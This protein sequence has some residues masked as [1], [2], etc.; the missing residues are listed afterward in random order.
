MKPRTDKEQELTHEVVSKM[1]SYDADTGVIRHL[2]RCKGVKC[3]SVAGTR[4]SR[5]IHIKINGRQYK[6]HRVAWMLH[7]GEWPNG[8]IDHR[9]EIKI[10]N[11][12][13]NLRVCTPS[14]N[15]A[16]AGLSKQNTTG[17]KNVSRSARHGWKVRITY[18]GKR[19]EWRRR[20]K[21]DAIKLA[22]E[23]R[24][25][26]FGEF[27]NHG[28]GVVKDNRGSGV[29]RHDDDEVEMLVLLSETQREGAWLV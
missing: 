14:Q 15:H 18:N 20:N 17:H 8:F 13:C 3:G 1:Y 10:D 21:E 2:R 28:E 26:F 19:H 12:I 9:N 24:I 4:T 5:Y 23:K 29:K 11:R 27:A 22:K 16:N 6:A 7:Y 25:E